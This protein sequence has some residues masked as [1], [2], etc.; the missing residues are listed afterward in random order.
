[1]EWPNSH[2]SSRKKNKTN[3]AYIS[4]YEVHGAKVVKNWYNNNYEELFSEKNKFC[5][6]SCGTKSGIGRWNNRK[7]SSNR[8]VPYITLKYS[9]GKEVLDS[10]KKSL[11]SHGAMMRLCHEGGKTNLYIYP[12][13][14]ELFD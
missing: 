8:S 2:F 11:S 10:D 6:V 7:I 13:K 14:P 5:T 9:V 4:I 3:Q 12:N 1:M